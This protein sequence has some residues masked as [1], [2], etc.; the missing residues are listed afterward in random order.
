MILTCAPFIPA[1]KNRIVGCR[2]A[3]RDAVSRL[4]RAFSVSITCVSAVARSLDQASPQAT[5]EAGALDKAMSQN[6]ACLG[7]AGGRVS[8]DQLPDQAALRP[9]V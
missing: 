2:H 8:A 3:H 5:A 7:P 1:A 6:E 4:G 9:N